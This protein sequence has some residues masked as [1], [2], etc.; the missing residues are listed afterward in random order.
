MRKQEETFVHR[1][2][3]ISLFL[4]WVTYLV[5]SRAFQLTSYNDL[6]TKP[7]QSIG[8]VVIYFV[9]VN[10]VCDNSH[11]RILRTTNIQFIGKSKESRE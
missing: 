2:Y 1:L 11:I 3:W 7:I 10:W 9:W 4:S 5:L 6:V 8:F